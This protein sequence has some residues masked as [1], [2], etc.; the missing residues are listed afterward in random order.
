MGSSLLLLIGIFL[1]S[2]T[3]GSCELPEESNV[4]LSVVICTYNGMGVIEP[5]MEAILQQSIDKTR[6]EV[7]LVDNN[8]DDGTTEYV[9]SLLPE[10]QN[11]RYIQED[12]QGLSY[13]RNTGID[14]AAGD[15]IVFLDDDSVAEPDYL[16]TLI[17][18]FKEYPS[19]LC[20]GGK[21]IPKVDFEVPWWML[22]KY[23]GYLAMGF[24]AGDEDIF[25]DN[26]RGP[27]GG[28]MAFKNFVFERFGR[29]D[30]RL[31]R[32][33][34]K[35]LAN[36]ED[37]LIKKIKQIEQSCLY[38]PDALVYHL[39]KRRR[40]GRKYLLNK[41]YYKGISDARSGY[42]RDEV[43]HPLGE[44]LWRKILR[45]P[46]LVV[47]QILAIIK[48]ILFFIGFETLP[49]AMI[50]LYNIGYYLEKWRM[51]NSEEGLEQ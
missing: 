48:K 14:E 21:I 49:L 50:V 25:L 2:K 9:K 46:K 27:T 16:E 15:I 17:R 47:L 8:S 32:Q 42:S 51:R 13:A 23:E 1:E 35:Y 37:V 34:G 4:F 26:M 41:A 39:A 40:V 45:V 28:N 20:L 7:L 38:T 18:K 10:Y 22:E 12:R 19:V 43:G 5:T 31:G 30:V 29:F 33:K 6:Y 44:P 3:G 11:L 36:E 24:D